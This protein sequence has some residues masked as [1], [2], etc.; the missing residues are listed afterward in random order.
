[1]SDNQFQLHWHWTYDDM[2][3]IAIWIHRGIAAVF[4]SVFAFV[5]VFSDVKNNIFTL[6][7]F[8]MH[9]LYD[10]LV[11]LFALKCQNTC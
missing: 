2:G 5:F 10:H 11:C 7:F 9:I 8:Q 3:S 1:M 6:Y 4:N